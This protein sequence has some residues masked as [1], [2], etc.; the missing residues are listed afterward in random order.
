MKVS[1]ATVFDAATSADQLSATLGKIYR[2]QL[3]RM[4][5]DL[6][7]VYQPQVSVGLGKIIGPQLGTA[8]LGKIIGPQLGTAGLG[9]IIGPQ[10]GTAGLGKIIGPQLSTA[11]LAK[12]FGPQLAR[13]TRDLA[14]VYQPQVS[15]G[16]GKIIEPL[17]IDLL[18]LEDLE[19]RSPNI[20]TVLS[21]SGQRLQKLSDVEVAAMLTVAAFLFVYFSLGLLV[22]YSAQA[23]EIAA[24]DGPTPFEAAMAIGA[25]VF[26]LRMNHSGRIKGK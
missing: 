20:N 18:A 6:A 3:A 1:V 21:T 17:L 25:L 8:G 5:R 26:W 12:V 23:A 4:T 9:K 16:L 11:G 24:T 7:T 2:P 14:T 19:L 10:L 15:V 13:M 22:K